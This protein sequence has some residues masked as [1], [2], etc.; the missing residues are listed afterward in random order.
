MTSEHCSNMVRSLRRIYATTKKN[1]GLLDAA[2]AQSFSKEFPRANKNKIEIKKPDSGKKRNR[3]T[4][5]GSGGGGG[6]KIAPKKT[7]AFKCD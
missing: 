6:R 1:M 2:L 7:E 5:G 3:S 4:S